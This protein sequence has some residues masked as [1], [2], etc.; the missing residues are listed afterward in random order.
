LKDGHTWNLFSIDC[1]FS[2]PIYLLLFTGDVDTLS[3][4]PHK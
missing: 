1:R 2:K 3:A 4:A